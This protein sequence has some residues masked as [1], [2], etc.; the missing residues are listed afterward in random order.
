MIFT[1]I[2]KRLKAEHAAQTK[3]E[4]FWAIG[5]KET[6]Y[7]ISGNAERS[8]LTRH[9]Q[10]TKTPTEKREIIKTKLLKE[11][12]KKWEETVA[13]LERIAAAPEVESITINVEW[14]NNKTWGSNPTASATIRT[15]T[16]YE[17]TNSRSISGCGYDKHSAAT[18]EAFNKSDAVLKILYA[19]WENALKTNKAAEMRQILGYGSGYG[20][21]PYFE[22]GVGI[23]SHRGIFK[24]CGYAWEDSA[25]GKMFDCH[26]IRK[27]SPGALKRMKGATHAYKNGG[28]LFVTYDDCVKYPKYDYKN[29]IY[30]KFAQTADNL[31]ALEVA[32]V[33]AYNN[34]SE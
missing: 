22:G 19:V 23:S 21:Q 3:S 31:N 11:R 27:I 7:S 9:Q 16:G 32:G 10:E 5:N 15:A 13:K 14:R 28:A 29:A 34:K 25:S 4:L 6:N 17:Y 20:A 1:N 8:Y 24:A 2:T 12:A 26:E 30:K 18:A 33:Y